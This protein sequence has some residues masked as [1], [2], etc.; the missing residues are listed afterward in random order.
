VVIIREGLLARALACAL[1]SRNYSGVA[2]PR[3]TRRPQ[4]ELL[5]NNNARCNS[6][7]NSQRAA[8]KKKVR[9]GVIKR[10]AE[11][12]MVRP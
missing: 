4:I 2:S 5:S 9:V 3:G 7:H 10:V 1:A 8:I 11:W 6:S 12:L